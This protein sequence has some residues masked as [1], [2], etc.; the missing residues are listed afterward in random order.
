MFWFWLITVV[1]MGFFLCVGLHYA[2]DEWH[3]TQGGTN[4]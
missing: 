2:A 4:R 3:S 1:V